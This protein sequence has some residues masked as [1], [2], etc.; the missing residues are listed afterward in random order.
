V[1]PIEE[2]EENLLKTTKEYPLINK[3]EERRGKE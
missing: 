3:F 1:V 2:E